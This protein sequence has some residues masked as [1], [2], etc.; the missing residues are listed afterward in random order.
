MERNQF[1]ETSQNAVRQIGT[2]QPSYYFCPAGAKN[3]A[4]VAAGA[5]NK[6]EAYV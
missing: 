6:K 5:T 1:S 2:D 4:L 3:G